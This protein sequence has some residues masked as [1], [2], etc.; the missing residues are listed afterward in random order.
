[1]RSHQKISDSEGGFTDTLDIQDYFGASVAALGDLDGDGTGDLA[2]GAY[3][4][5]DSGPYRGAVWVL[6]L[7]TNGTVKSH[8]KINDTEGGFT[9]TLDDFDRFGYSVA[10]LG[11][12][13]GDGFRDLAVGANYDSDGGSYRGA[14]WVLFLNANGTVKS[15]QKISDTEGGF[16]GTLDD[17]DWFGCSVAALED[18]D[19]DGTGD[20]AVGAVNDDDGG[21]ARGA[22]WVLFLNTN[23]TVKSHQKIS[24]TKGGFTGTLG[25]G[26][27]FGSSA[28]LLGD[29]NSDGVGDLAVGADGDDDGGNGRGAVWML[30]LNTDGTVDSHQKI[31]DTEGGFAGTLDDADHFGDSVSGLG[32]LDGDGVGDLA[33][34][35]PYDDDGGPD[36]GA[37]W[38][39][40]LDDVGQGDYDGDGDVDLDDFTIFAECMEGPDAI[41]APTPPTTSDDC[42]DTFDFEPDNDVDL[43]DFAEFQEAFTGQIF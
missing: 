22:I 26:D 20:L 6:F 13:D 27:W 25:D 23:G 9:G 32:D 35:A 16:I 18:L 41:P 17:W 4:D 40:F 43:A 29:L 2:V 38:V 1:M 7:N 19:R 5:D 31:S 12:I 39:L 28:S 14:V 24:S 30:F 34:G 11:D 8:Q 37:V 15:H 33:V 42:L 36:R 3:G 10:G 21:T